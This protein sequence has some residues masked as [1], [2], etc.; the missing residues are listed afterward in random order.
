M[1]ERYDIKV[2]DNQKGFSFVIHSLE[3]RRNVCLL[4]C[5]KFWRD[6]ACIKMIYA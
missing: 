5:K 6:Y 2:K 4:S 1:V 3:L